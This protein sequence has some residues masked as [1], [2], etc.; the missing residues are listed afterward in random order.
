MPYV[1][2][3]ADGSCTW[4]DPAEDYQLQ[5]SESFSDVATEPAPTPERVDAQ[6]KAK[7]LADLTALE[8]ENLMPRVTREFL[9]AATLQQ[10]AQLGLSAAQLLNPSD[11]AYSPGFK[12]MWDFNQQT[13]ALRRQL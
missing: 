2:N 12:K 11:P 13:V 5:P 6:R 8:R 1:L 7:A 4:H 9:I 10:A 3:S